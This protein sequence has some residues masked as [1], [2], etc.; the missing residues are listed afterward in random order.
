M[1]M[2]VPVIGRG[3]NI[4]FITWKHSNHKSNRI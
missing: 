3:N 2:Y 1:Y 4:I